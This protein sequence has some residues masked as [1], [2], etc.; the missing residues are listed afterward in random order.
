MTSLVPAKVD[1]TADIFVDLGQ[2]PW[3]RVGFRG[4]GINVRFVGDPVAERP[5]ERFTSIYLPDPEDSECPEPPRP[6]TNF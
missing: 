4:F 2:K 1:P 5:Q 6:G 3:F